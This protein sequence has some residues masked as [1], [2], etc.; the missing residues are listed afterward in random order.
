LDF[1]FRTGK[2]YWSFSLTEKINGQLGMPKDLFRMILLGTP[3]ETTPNLYD[4]RTLGA[5]LT[6][7]TEAALGYSKIL[8]DGGRLVR[9]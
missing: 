4:L 6:A 2:S 3:N 5:D 9:K 1:G 8:N 7:Y